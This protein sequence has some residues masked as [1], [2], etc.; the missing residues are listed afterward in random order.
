M[1]AVVNDVQV[2]TKRI[3][4][5]VDEGADRA[6]ALAFNLSLLTKHTQR[7]GEV[8]RPILTRN[9]LIAKEGHLAK[10]QNCAFPRNKMLPWWWKEENPTVVQVGTGGSSESDPPLR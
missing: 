1:L 9:G 4:H 5:T 2:K 3:L 7:R 6:V 8:A 10:A